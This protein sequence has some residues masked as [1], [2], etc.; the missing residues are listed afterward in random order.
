MAGET[1]FGQVQAIK[2]VVSISSAIRG[3]AFRLHWQRPGPP[4]D[5]CRLCQR[6]MLYAKFKIPVKGVDQAF[7][8]CQCLKSNG[9]DKI[10]S[11]FR[12]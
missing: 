11:I 9:I 12:H 5:I 8:A 10:H 2:V 4:K 7:M 3:P 1:I 6:Y